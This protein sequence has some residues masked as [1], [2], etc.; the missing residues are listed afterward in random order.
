MRAAAAYISQHAVG[1]ASV[2]VRAVAT[3]ALTLYDSNS[4]AASTLLSSLENLARERGE[5]PA[6]DRARERPS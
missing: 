4:M 2:Y 5:N 6:W 1:V 3:F